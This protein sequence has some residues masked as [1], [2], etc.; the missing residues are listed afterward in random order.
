MTTPVVSSRSKPAGIV[1]ACDEGAKAP[2]SASAIAHAVAHLPIKRR[3]ACCMGTSRMCGL[4]IAA[5]DPT[6]GGAE[7]KRAL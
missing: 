4:Q 2:P 1:I 7:S 5:F 6:P 3:R